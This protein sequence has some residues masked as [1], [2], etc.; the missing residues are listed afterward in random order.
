MG[1]TTL[2]EHIIPLVEGAQSVSRPPH[3]LGPEKEAEVKRQVV[4]LLRKDLI[5]PASGA[6]N[7]H[8]VLVKK[9]DEK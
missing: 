8:V 9:K 1:R 2:L 6:C 7:L 4:D 5:E 3:C